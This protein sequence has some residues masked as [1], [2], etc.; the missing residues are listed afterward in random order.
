[1]TANFNEAAESL[2]ATPSGSPGQQ[3]AEAAMQGSVDGLVGMAARSMK[4]NGPIRPAHR[5]LKN[6]PQITREEHLKKQGALETE[7]EGRLNALESRLDKLTGLLEQMVGSGPSSPAPPPS[8]EA[9]TTPEPVSD[10]SSTKS[11]IVTSMGPVPGNQESEPENLIDDWGSDEP[12]IDP[13]AEKVQI[14]CQQAREDLNRK[15]PYSAF[16]KEI[17]GIARAFGYTGWP[18]ELKRAFNKRFEGLLANPEF[19]RTIVEKVLQ[20]DMGHGVGP[21]KVSK[22]AVLVAGFNAFGFAEV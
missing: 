4:D 10:E 5:I 12:G 11:E 8:P 14:L 9:E 21:N 2:G 13:W 15:D 7:K 22:L 16:R 3:E 17:A 19:L 1:M 6:Q 18:P 20:M